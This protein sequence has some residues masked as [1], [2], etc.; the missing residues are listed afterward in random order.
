[1]LRKGDRARSL[2]L[3]NFNN[4]DRPQE[5]LGRRQRG[6][7]GGIGLLFAIMPISDSQKNKNILSIGSAEYLTFS[8]T[9]HDNCLSTEYEHLLVR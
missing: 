4:G 1:M 3:C 2:M 9:L 6:C 8:S 5:M 7:Q